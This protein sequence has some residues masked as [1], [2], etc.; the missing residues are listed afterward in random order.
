MTTTTTR[1]VLIAMAVAVGALALT[2][3]ALAS[4]PHLKSKAIVINK[5]IGGLKLNVN[6]KTAKAE[7]GSTKGG[8]CTPKSE[9][10]WGT[11]TS[12]TFSFVLVP[13]KEGATPLVASINISAPA[14]VSS[15]GTVYHFRG[16][17]MK[18]KTSKRIGLGSSLKALKHAYPHMKVYSTSKGSGDYV[19][20][21]KGSVADRPSTQFS[22]YKSRVVDIAEDSRELGG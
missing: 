2:A 22:V 13:K 1:R 17:L 21:G 15:T 4:L 12:G 20:Y 18:L 8:I 7:V 10:Q 6:Y 14:K 16:P 19:I 11:T 5:S 9:C 3:S